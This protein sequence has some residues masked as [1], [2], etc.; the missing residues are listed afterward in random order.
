MKNTKEI[1]PIISAV[2]CINI[3][4]G[5]E[6]KDIS[7]LIKYLLT[8]CLNSNA[9]LLMLSCLGKTKQDIMPEIEQ[10]LKEETKFYKE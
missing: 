1:L 8:R 4:N 3:T 7:K 2:Y 10:L 6:D 5:N 9:N